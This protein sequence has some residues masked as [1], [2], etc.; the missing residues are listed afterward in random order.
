MV[1]YCVQAYL[2]NFYNVLMRTTLRSI[3]E[4]NGYDS[5]YVFVL[6]RFNLLCTLLQQ[7]KFGLDA[8][9]RLASVSM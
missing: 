8:A 9:N 3:L 6:G 4:Y 7:R 5:V 2:E 1:G